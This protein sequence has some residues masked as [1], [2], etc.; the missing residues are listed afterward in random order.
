MMQVMKAKLQKK[1]IGERR[2]AH[3]TLSQEFERESKPAQAKLQVLRRGLQLRDGRP[4]GSNV[5][6]RCSSY[7]KQTCAHDVGGVYLHGLIRENERAAE[8]LRHA[9]RAA[10]GGGRE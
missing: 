4:R 5:R 8:Q 7:T 10:G 9:A 2:E 3:V 6:L 1:T